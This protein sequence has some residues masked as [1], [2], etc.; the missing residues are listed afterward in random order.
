MRGHGI[1]SMGESNF[2]RVDSDQKSLIHELET[3]NDMNTVYTSCGY[4][5][6]DDQFLCLSTCNCI[7]FNLRCDG[8]VSL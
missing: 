3:E 7:D 8:S 6:N 1:N 2:D 4:N 5:C